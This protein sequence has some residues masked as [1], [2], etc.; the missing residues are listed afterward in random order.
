MKTHPPTFRSA[1]LL[2]AAVLLLAL[3]SCQTTPTQRVP[4]PVPVDYEP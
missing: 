3:A 1:F 2:L 4:A